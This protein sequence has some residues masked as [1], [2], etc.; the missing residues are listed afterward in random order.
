M[1]PG[2]TYQEECIDKDLE[3]LVTSWIDQQEW[4]NILKRR[5]QQYGYE[6]SYHVRG[7]IKITKP[8][9][10][11]LKDIADWLTVNN[12]I[13]PDQ[14]IVNEYYKDQVIGSHI[15][16]EVFGPTIVS[17]SLLEPCAM[18]FTKE[19]ERKEMTLMP[20]SLLILRDEARYKWKHEIPKRIRINMSDD[21]VYTKKEDYR[22]ISLT[23]RSIAK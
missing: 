11:P 10:G 22:R 2:L 20:R 14:C 4:S 9:T 1:I 12:V 19:S 23:F 3:F 6:Y 5:T 7:Q 15:D 18:I 21:S 13:A 8:I 16:S 17:I